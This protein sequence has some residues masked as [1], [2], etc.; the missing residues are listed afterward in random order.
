MQITDNNCTYA[1]N[2]RMIWMQMRICK[3]DNRIMRIQI[4]L[5][6]ASAVAFSTLV[7]S[8]LAFIKYDC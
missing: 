1:D 6:T 5:I 8:I 2:I 3:S 4:L 7:C